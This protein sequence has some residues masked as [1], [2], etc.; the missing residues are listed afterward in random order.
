ME[1]FFQHC[2][3]RVRTQLEHWLPTGKDTPQY[4]HQA[5]RY[6]ALGGGKYIRP[7]M[8]YASGKVLGVPD[9]CL[10]APACAIEMIHA[11][12]LIHDDL[13]AMD[14]DDLR[15]GVPT[16][17]RAYDEATAILAGDSLQALAF[18]VI[19]HDHAMQ[20]GDAARIRMLETLAL[21]SGS[22][23]MAGGQA[24]DLA[25]VGQKMTLA[26]LEQM[27]TMKT[28]SLIRASLELGALA[29]PDVGKQRF[30]A[31]SRYGHYAGLAFQVTDDILDVATDTRVLGKPQG[32][33]QARNKP[34]YPELLGLDGA[35]AAAQTFCGQAIDSLDCFSSEAD[36]LRDIGYYI[37][38][39]GK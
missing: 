9:T 26:Q 13:P 16:C 28:A 3:E 24:I 35:K 11:Y 1:D 39:R 21:T 4:L 2:R 15:R 18:Y 17:H 23:G 27:H 12:S 34:T 33:D 31:L 37:V 19:A 5:M 20:N 7:I 25:A 10:D 14:N 6:S 36:I 30:T 8:V 22:H 38:R 29:C 32:S